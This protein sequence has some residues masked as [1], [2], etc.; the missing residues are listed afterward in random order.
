LANKNL[1]GRRRELAKGD[2]QEFNRKLRKGCYHQ[3][4]NGDSIHPKAAVEEI[5]LIFANDD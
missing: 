2:E 3:L 1:P 5:C 4:A